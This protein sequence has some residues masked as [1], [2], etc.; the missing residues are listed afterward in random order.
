M[1]IPRTKFLTPLLQ[2]YNT[3]MSRPHVHSLL[4]RFMKH[5]LVPGASCLD[6]GAGSGY[7]AAH[8]AKATGHVTCIEHVPQLCDFMRQNMKNCVCHVIL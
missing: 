8:M 2:Q 4:L 6:I 1:Y 5:K 7:L 3:A